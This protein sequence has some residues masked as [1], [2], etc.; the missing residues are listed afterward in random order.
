MTKPEERITGIP[1]LA[2]VHQAHYI[3]DCRWTGC[4]DDLFCF[5]STLRGG[6]SGAGSGCPGELAVDGRASP[7][8]LRLSTVPLLLGSV[9]LLRMLPST[10]CNGLPGTSATGE[11]PSLVNPSVRALC[12][13]CLSDVDLLLATLGWTLPTSFQLPSFTSSSDASSSTPT[14]PAPVTGGGVMS[15]MNQSWWAIKNSKTS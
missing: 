10:D 3:C 13:S 1:T 7:S 8:P 2:V 15:S 4:I 14:V 11:S 5:L 12:T 9:R 6:S